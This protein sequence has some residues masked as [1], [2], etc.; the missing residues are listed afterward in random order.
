MSL[1]LFLCYYIKTLWILLKF[2]VFVANFILIKHLL[3]SLQR[4]TGE[5]RI[6]VLTSLMH[7]VANGLFLT[8]KQ[9]FVVLQLEGL[10]IG[11]SSHSH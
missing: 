3:S 5:S 1:S 4:S 10:L 9:W 11:P 8:E 6:I 2:I 7:I